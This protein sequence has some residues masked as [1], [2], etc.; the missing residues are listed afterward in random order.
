MLWWPLT[1]ASCLPCDWFPWIIQRMDKLQVALGTEHLAWT[2]VTSQYSCLRLYILVFE[3]EKTTALCFHLYSPTVL[4]WFAIQMRSGHQS[5]CT[6]TPV[7][8]VSLLTCLIPEEYGRGLLEWMGQLLNRRSTSQLLDNWILSWTQ[9][10]LTKIC[11]ICVGC[12]G[13]KACL[14]VGH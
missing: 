3:G 10:L 5:V 6:T 8:V 9:E 7:R 14:L 13:C 1:L 12:Q 2:Q 11:T 4:T